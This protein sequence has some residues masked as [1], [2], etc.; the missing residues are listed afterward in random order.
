MEH[1]LKIF[2]AHEGH[3]NLLEEGLTRG[4]NLHGLLEFAEL[5]PRG[6]NDVI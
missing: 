4:I 6:A 2:L 3:V 5:G 1:I